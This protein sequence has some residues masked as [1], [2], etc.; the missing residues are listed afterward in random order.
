[1]F[2][3]AELSGPSDRHRPSC[4]SNL[5]HHRRHVMLRGL[6]ADEEPLGN[7]GVVQACTHESEHFRLA[8]GEANRVCLRLRARTS[9]NAYHPAFSQPASQP[10][11]RWS[12]TE[13][14][15]DPEACLIA[16]S[17]PSARANASS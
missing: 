7:L 17:S 5:A 16:A 13:A 14:V 4:C 15:K 11:R 1:M 9:G 12:C 3:Q 8:G 2:E 10:G 6:L